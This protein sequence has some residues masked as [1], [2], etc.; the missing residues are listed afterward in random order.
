MQNIISIITALPGS[1][2]TG[3]LTLAAGL[4]GALITLLGALITLK[5]TRSN[6][7][8]ELRKESYTIILKRLKEASKRADIVDNGYNSGEFG[9]DTPHFYYESPNRVEQEQAAYNAWKSC[10]E[11]FDE[12]CLILSDKF[13]ARFKQLLKSLPTEYDYFPPDSA[14]EEAKSLGDA[15][16]DLFAIAR[17]ECA[18]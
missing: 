10:R 6:R 12:N 15:Y 7:V 3:V 14:A 4:L 9:S 16:Q 2:I 11:A 17:R 18:P 8:W 1:L 5:A 13:L